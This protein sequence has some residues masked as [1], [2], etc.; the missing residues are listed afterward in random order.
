MAHFNYDSKYGKKALDDM[1]KILQRRELAANLPSLS[2]ALEQNAMKRISEVPE[3]LKVAVGPTKAHSGS[4][5]MAEVRSRPGGSL[6]FSEAAL[7]WLH[8][9]GIDVSAPQGISVAK[10]LNRILGLPFD[11]QNMLFEAS[12][13]ICFFLYLFL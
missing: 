3:L 8:M 13:A 11:P 4:T 5:F 12:R 6:Y 1:I 2:D 10:F 9:V 7:V